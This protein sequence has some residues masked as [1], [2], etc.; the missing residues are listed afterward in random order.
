MCEKVGE[1]PPCENVHLAAD[2][3]VI[4]EPVI[5]HGRLNMNRHDHANTSS[6]RGFRSCCS[7]HGGVQRL[8]GP[9]RQGRRR[10]TAEQ[11]QR[12]DDPRRPAGARASAV[13]SGTGGTIVPQGGSSASRQRRKLRRHV[14]HEERQGRARNGA[15]RHHHRARQLRQHGR[16]DG[17]RGDEHPKQ[18]RDHSQH[19]LRRFPDDHALASSQRSAYRQRVRPRYVDLH[20]SNR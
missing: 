3:P 1:S 2:L 16:G 11:R 6:C 8:I 19:G 4:A 12:R 15:G 9:C 7:R 20:R 13:T 14:R 18:L 17:R 10:A 5:G